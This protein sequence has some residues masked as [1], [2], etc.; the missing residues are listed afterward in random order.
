[1]RKISFFFMAAATVISCITIFFSVR[2]MPEIEDTN[3]TVVTTP[4][5]VYLLKTYNGRLAVFEQGSDLPYKEFD[6]N[7]N[8]LS[9]YDKELLENGITA[10]SKEKIRKLIEDYTS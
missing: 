3:T 8:T 2:A 9:D 1:M 7:I 5:V 4:S 6:I 10:D